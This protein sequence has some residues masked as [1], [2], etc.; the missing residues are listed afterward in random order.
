[1]LNTPC[2]LK[3]L[4]KMSSPHYLLANIDNSTNTEKLSCHSIQNYDLTTQ[5]KPSELRSDPHRDKVQTGGEC[6]HYFHMLC[7]LAQSLEILKHR[8]DVPASPEEFMKKITGMNVS[9]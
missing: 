2:K 3:M 1:M 9:N 8:F 6:L 5:P 4:L 7:Q